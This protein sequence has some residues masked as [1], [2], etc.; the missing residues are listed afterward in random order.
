MEVTKDLRHIYK[1][2]CFV[3][4]QRISLRNTK[5]ILCSTKKILSNLQTL[6]L[7]YV[8]SK[9]YVL[10][11]AVY[12]RTTVCFFWGWMLFVCRSAD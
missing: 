3:T 10:Q 8:C 1:L 11:S 4:L 9:S 5:E 2:K 12:V 6:A 7:Y